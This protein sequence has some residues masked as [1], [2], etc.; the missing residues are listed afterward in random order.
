MTSNRGNEGA[1]SQPSEAGLGRVARLM[2][3]FTTPR[4][5]A[6]AV[7]A[8]VAGWVSASLLED[9][10]EDYFRFVSISTPYTYA[11]GFVLAVLFT[12]GGILRRPVR[13]PL[14]VM[15]R[16]AAGRFAR[17]ESWTSSSG[18]SEVHRT[19]RTLFSRPDAPVR[20][21]GATVWVELGKDW[22]GE[23]M[24]HRE[25]VVHLKRRPPVHFFV[26]ERDG[27]TT[28]TAFSGD[29][30]LTGM[31]DVLKLCDEMSAAAVRTA[32]EATSDAPG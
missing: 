13:L 32:R 9:L 20:G 24:R 18:V 21:V 22:A 28:V 1:G 27:R 8:A 4:R 31:W 2:L 15:R 23:G 17:E 11:A 12:Q 29:L 25:A 6:A 3:Y 16:T 10:A 14:D 19:L 7:L 5:K 30:R 26:E